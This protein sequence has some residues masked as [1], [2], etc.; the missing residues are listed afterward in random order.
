MNASR[1]D[2]PRTQV[3]ARSRT[4]DPVSPPAMELCG[5]HFPIDSPTFCHGTVHRVGVYYHRAYYERACSRAGTAMPPVV[6]FHCRVNPATIV[7]RRCMTMTNG[8]LQCLL[9]SYIYDLKSLISNLIY[10][11]VRLL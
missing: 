8:I 3:A 4:C 2:M 5:K 7:M 10:L 6:R 11:A 9:V 1:L